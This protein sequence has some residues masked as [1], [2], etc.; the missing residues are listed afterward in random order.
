M[1]EDYRSTLLGVAWTLSSLSAV[2]VG[3]R[4]FCRIYYGH[5]L[6]WDDFWA[7]VTLVRVQLHHTDKH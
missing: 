6:G 3:L 7:T 5:K 1:T 2:F 4:Y